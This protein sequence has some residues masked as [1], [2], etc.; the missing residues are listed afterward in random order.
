MINK[1]RAILTRRDKKF[2]LLLVVFSIFISIIEVIGVSAIMPFMSVTMDFNTIH[3]NQYF[4]YFYKLFQFEKEINF[5]IIFGVVLVLFYILRSAINIFYTYTLSK[6]SQG[7]YHLI[8]YRLFEN[9]MGM[10]YK[11][12]VKKNS[13]YLTKTIVSEASNLT[14]LISSVLFMMS[15]IFIVIFI[16]GMM[17]YVNYQITL[18]LT[19]FLLINAILMMKT[20]SRK[21][22]KQ[23]TNRA[24]IQQSFYEIVNKSFGNFKLIKLQTNDKVVLD[25]FAD[26]SYSY[27]KTNIIALTLLQVP[28]LLLEA[29]AFS[30]IIIIILYLVWKYENDISS[31]LA[32]LSMFVLALYRLMPS[33]N[34]I[35]TSYNNILFIHK[36]LEIVHNDLMYDSEVLGK[37]SVFFNKEIS[38]KNLNFEYEENKAVLKDISLTID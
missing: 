33:V 36:S 15:E 14:G 23:G 37:N 21:I 17:L 7:R 26:A 25:E 29:I 24:S 10:S 28:R 18:A 3:S 22:K 19:L 2:F 13:S 35:L 30:M 8:A 38:I 32:M 9:Y 27:S 6:F 5:I 12:F 20:I 34:R 4:S 31:V 16:Y 11:N 1:L